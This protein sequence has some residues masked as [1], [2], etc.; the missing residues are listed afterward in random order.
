M[1]EKKIFNASSVRKMTHEPA[2]QKF[3]RPGGLDYIVCLQKENAV[4][5][6]LVRDPSDPSE[7]PEPFEPSTPLHDAAQPLLSAW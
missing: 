5:I 3:C 4:V 2:R 1:K 6:V 7:P